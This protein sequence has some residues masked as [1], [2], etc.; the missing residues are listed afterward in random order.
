MINVFL[1][2]A[3]VL[4]MVE[5]VTY[6]GYLWKH[7]FIDPT[8]VMSL[9]IFCLLL[10]RKKIYFS[11]QIFYATLFVYF[12]LN[13]LDV[14][15]YHNFVYSKYHIQPENILYL[16][17]FSLITYLINELRI[18]Y[19]KPHWLHSSIFIIFTYILITNI[20][21][22]INLAF[23]N[24]GYILFHPKDSYTQKMSHYWGFF[25]DYMV[26]VKSN[27]EENAVIEIPPQ[28]SP[29]LSS[30]N[31]LL[32]RYFLYP[33]RIVQGDINLSNSQSGIDYILVSYG[34]W[35][36]SDVSKYGWPKNMSSYKNVIYMNSNDKKWGIIILKK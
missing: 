28:E 26:F 30:G 32:V 27:T 16:V 34:E 3:Y 12:I 23:S 18:K 21:L 35:P 14:Y 4:G 20:S 15:K 11:K 9:S 17:V 36:D 31:S 6:K 24:I 1:L 5:V 29:W 7:L 33:R 22:T 19:Y 2:A 13:F 8:I 25:Y 10:T